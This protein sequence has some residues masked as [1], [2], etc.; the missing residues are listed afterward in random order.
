MA[1]EH[2]AGNSYR[3]LDAKPRNEDWLFA[4]GEVVRCE[5]QCFPDDFEAL[6]AVVTPTDQSFITP[7]TDLA[8]LTPIHASGSSWLRVK[9]W[10]RAKFP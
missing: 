1:A 4:T 10:L 2:V 6:V 8:F 9:S 7:A 5:M 3:I